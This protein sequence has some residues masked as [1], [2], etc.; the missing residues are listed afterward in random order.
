MSAYS[1]K[2]SI[3]TY[4]FRSLQHE[5]R[6]LETYRRKAAN[7]ATLWQP[8]ANASWRAASLEWTLHREV[9]TVRRLW[10][11]AAAALARGF[12][13][14]RSGF[15][16]SP[17]QLILAF[18]FAIAGRARDAFTS[19]ASVAPNLPT[20]ALHGARAFRGSRAHL[21]L[22]E[23]YALL[24]RTLVER[25]GIPAAVAQL[26]QAAQEETDRGWWESQFPDA[27]EA[28]W[29]MG[30][31]EAMCVLLRIVARLVTDNTLL[32]DDSEI[33]FR[34]EQAADEFAFIIDATLL[35]LEQFTDADVNHHPKLEVWL[36]GVALCIL[37]SGAGLR[38][39]WLAARYDAHAPGYTRLP[40]EL[41]R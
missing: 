11:E 14:K 40:I 19:L 9:D 28:A 6:M 23:G 41:L 21:L 17:D 35:R 30:E 38:M 16:P 24:A 36:P 10:A 3:D 2:A 13:R 1:A 39:D 25:K 37:A 32:L 26:L 5:R 29:R 12:E 4:S 31:H 18:H 27:L 8:L 33:D 34:D 22:A 20:G 7:D 15:D